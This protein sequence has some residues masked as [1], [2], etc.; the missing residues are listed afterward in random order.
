M[1]AA[2]VCRIRPM[3][4]KI[5]VQGREEAEHVIKFLHEHGVICSAPFQEPELHEPP[6]YSAI[7]GLKTQASFTAHELQ[8]LLEQ[9]GRIEL[10]FEG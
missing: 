8:T 4:W 5:F 10:A 7:I 3:A 6:I 9:D 1:Q 2:M